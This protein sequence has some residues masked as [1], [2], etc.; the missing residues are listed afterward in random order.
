MLSLCTKLVLPRTKSN[1]FKAVASRLRGMPYLPKNQLRDFFACF[2]CFCLESG[3]GADAV[4]AASA[5]A[6]ASW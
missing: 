1:D 6:T 3:G 2:T 4:F 5:P